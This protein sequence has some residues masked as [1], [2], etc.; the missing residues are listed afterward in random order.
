M[1]QSM[2]TY[3]SIG[4]ASSYFADSVYHAVLSESK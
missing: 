1:K 3:A 2:G 4:I